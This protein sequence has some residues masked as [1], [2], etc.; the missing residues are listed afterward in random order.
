MSIAVP[1]TFVW[2]F[3]D[4]NKTL[5]LPSVKTRNRQHEFPAVRTRV[6][7]ATESEYLIKLY[8]LYY[9]Q[10]ACLPVILS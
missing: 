2:L 9:R 7:V 3:V 1:E 4:F 6:F 10:I 5:L 8:W